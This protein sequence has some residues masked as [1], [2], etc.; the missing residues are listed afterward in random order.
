MS[1]LLLCIVATSLIAVVFKFTQ[2]LK[3]KILPVIV[4][5]YGVAIVG[6]L[7]LNESSFNI[8]EIV[9]EPWL[10]H[11]VYLGIAFL[12]MFFL[13]GFSVQKTGIT[14]TAISTKMSVVFPVAFSIFYYSEV[15]GVL[16]ILGICLAVLAIVLA[17]YKKDTKDS[18]VKKYW[19]IPALLFVGIGINDIVIKYTQDKFLSDDSVAVFTTI[20][21]IIACFWGLIITI[22]TKITAKD[23]FSFKTLITGVSLGIVNFS[24][25]YFLIR[26]LGN[27][28]MESSIIFGINNVGIILLSV[29]LAFLLFK[30]RITKINWIGIGLAIIAITI[31]GGYLV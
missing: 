13:I 3:V 10:Y 29:G 18:T 2:K 15:A 24:S 25:L 28:T 23:F 31:M 6:S 12:G 30:E 4:I 9:D 5:N 14:A 1:F 7:L 19:Y 26:A 16:K 27:S 22:F 17:V 21:F 11:A 20:T 8:S